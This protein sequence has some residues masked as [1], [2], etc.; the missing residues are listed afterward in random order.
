MAVFRGYKSYFV[1]KADRRTIG[2]ELSGVCLDMKPS[3]IHS[4]GPQ[5]NHTQALT[6]T[7]THTHRCI[8]HQR[9]KGAKALIKKQLSVGI[10]FVLLYNHL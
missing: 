8:C 7:H 2:E 10:E 5:G 4:K 1:I 3:H 6:H 9:L